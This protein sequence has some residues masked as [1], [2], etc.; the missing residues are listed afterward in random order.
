MRTSCIEIGR[1]FLPAASQNVTDDQLIEQAAQ[2]V[3]RHP[4]VAAEITLATIDSAMKRLGAKHPALAQ[5][6]QRVVNNLCLARDSTL[7]LS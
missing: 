5:Q 4:E 6:L 7:A 3:K 2:A 1:G